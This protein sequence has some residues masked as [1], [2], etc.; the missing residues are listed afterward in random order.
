M[1]VF[2][3]QN[4]TYVTEAGEI[5]TDDGLQTSSTMPNSVII[6]EGEYLYRIY[7]RLYR[8]LYVGI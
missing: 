2:F 8:K 5:T 6:H 3:L 1:Y 7:F 4:V